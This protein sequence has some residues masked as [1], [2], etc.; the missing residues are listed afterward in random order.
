M[1]TS[2]HLP[3]RSAFLRTSGGFCTKPDLNIWSSLLWVPLGPC[4]RRNGQIVPWRWLARLG[5]QNPSPPCCWWPTG[6]PLMCRPTLG[7]GKAEA[8]GRDWCAKGRHLQWSVYLGPVRKVLCEALISLG[9]LTWV[10][11]GEWRG[12]WSDSDCCHGWAALVFRILVNLQRG[13]V[14]DLV[15]WELWYEMRYEVS[16]GQPFC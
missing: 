13:L 2:S 14:G 3:Q 15:P 9:K 6:R 5:F 12:V 10:S 8:V 16:I 1:S 7:T 4:S 11:D